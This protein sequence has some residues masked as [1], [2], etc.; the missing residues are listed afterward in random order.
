MAAQTTSIIT[1]KKIQNK[2]C[3][4]IK[5]SKTKT[6]KI[7]FELKK[8]FKVKNFFFSNQTFAFQITLIQNSFRGIF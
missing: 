5:L 1:W 2:N 7:G 6:N 3:F 8:N 4:I